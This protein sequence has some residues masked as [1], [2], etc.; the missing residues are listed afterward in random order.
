MSA[1]SGF[2]PGLYEDC[3]GGHPLRDRRFRES[4]LLPIFLLLL[5]LLREMLD[6]ERAKQRLGKN[7]VSASARA[8]CRHRRSLCSVLCSLAIDGSRRSRLP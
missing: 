5:L 6:S 7:P 1:M 8:V 3:N 2:K 4:T